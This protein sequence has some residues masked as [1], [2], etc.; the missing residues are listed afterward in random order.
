MSSAT[1]RALQG[2]CWVLAGLLAALALIWFAIPPHWRFA[3]SA[4]LGLERHGVRLEISG[5]V[6]DANG[7]PAAG[8]DIIGEWQPLDARI[9]SHG[10]FRA[11]SNAD[12]RYQCV[13]LFHSSGIERIAELRLR[14]H[15]VA[16]GQFGACEPAPAHEI[17]L[18]ARSVITVDFRLGSLRPAIQVRI[19]D[20]A[21]VPVTE[22]F[23]EARPADGS[24]RPIGWPQRYKDFPDGVAHLAIPDAP[25]RVEVHRYGGADST[26]VGPFDPSALPAGIDVTLGKK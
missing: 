9:G 6:T 22:C 21:G 18:P 24:E 15:I 23:V 14:W 16:R 2:V 12:G 11:T 13:H 7:R 19:R 4:Y 8:A 10:M 26:T 1:R 20:A 3:A 25:F 5:L 17:E